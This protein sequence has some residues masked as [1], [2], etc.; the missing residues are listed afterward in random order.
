MKI[1]ILTLFPEMFAPL[2][3][4][5]IGRAREKKLVEINVV[6]IRDYSLDKHKKCDD[7]AFGGGAGMLMTAQ[8]VCDAIE[9]VDPTRK[10]LRIY[11]SPKGKKLTQ[12]EVRRLAG[13]EEILLLCGHYE[14]IDQR[15]IDLEIDEEISIGDYIL[16]GGELPAMVI[17][18]SVCR[19]V[20]GVLGSEQST[21]E[22][23]FC[24]DLLEYP[25]YTRPAEFRGLKVPYV[26]LNGNHKE[27]NLWRRQRQVGLT[28]ER[29]PDLAKDNSAIEEHDRYM[30]QQQEKERKRLL[31]KQKKER[32]IKDEE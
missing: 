9:A 29:R 18:D 15:A 4:S 16:T 5:I 14:G 12:A 17:V 20:D 30:A 13:F 26:L 19:Y 31:R 22:E 11:T 1:S 23:T 28:R 27:I 7:Y 21:Q 25:Q 8:P 2:E 24:D 3:Q 32:K 10:A 6:N